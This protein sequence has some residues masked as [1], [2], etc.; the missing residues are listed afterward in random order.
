VECV[1]LFCSLVPNLKFQIVTFA[2]FASFRPMMFGTAYYYLSFVF[3]QNQFG[4]LCS[5]SLLCGAVA[6]LLI[7]SELLFVYDICDGSFTIINCIFLVLSSFALSFP[8]F[9][10]CQ[11]RYIRPH[12]MESVE[13]LPQNCNLPVPSTINV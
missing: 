3:P 1:F 2:I 4:K 6:N 13:N 5:L 7:Y 10:V 11:A 12:T 9:L 8:I